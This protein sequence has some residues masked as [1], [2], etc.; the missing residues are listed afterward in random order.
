MQFLSDLLGAPVDR[1]EVRETTALGAAYLAGLQ[2]GLL[3]PPGPSVAHWR[4]DR[5]FTPRMAREE[6][7]RRY[8]VWKDAV[9]RVLTT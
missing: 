3:P 8:A 5:L 1:P 2:A 9:K 7:D 6:A 4:I